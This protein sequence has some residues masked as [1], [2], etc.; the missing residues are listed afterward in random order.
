MMFFFV[1]WLKIPPF[2]LQGRVR[3]VTIP[4]LPKKYFV[5]QHIDNKHDMDA[6]QKNCKN[7]G[8]R[9]LFIRDFLS[10]FVTT[11]LNFLIT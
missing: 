9:C 8:P 3:G 2:L 11:E 6:R 4:F 1:F 7:K 10:I 5:L